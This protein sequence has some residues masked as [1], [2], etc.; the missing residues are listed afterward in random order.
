MREGYTNWD[1][2]A[3]EKGGVMI[4]VYKIIHGVENVDRET[5]FSI[6]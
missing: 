6:S 3:W 2:L 1:C 5:F 4:E